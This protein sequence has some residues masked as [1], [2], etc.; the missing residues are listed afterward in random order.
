MTAFEKICLPVEARGFAMRRGEDIVAMVD[1]EASFGAAI[2]QRRE[3]PQAILVQLDAYVSPPGRM[4]AR[5][6]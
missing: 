3:H 5:W 6:C 2:V 1:G 4:V